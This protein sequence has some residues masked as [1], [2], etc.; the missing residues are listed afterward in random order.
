MIAM[1]ILYLRGFKGNSLTY[2]YIIHDLREKS[3][4][5]NCKVIVKGDKG[6]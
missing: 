2:I 1:D 6:A 4:G 5:F 3:K